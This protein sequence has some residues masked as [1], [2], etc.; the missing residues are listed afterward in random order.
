MR[1]PDKNEFLAPPEGQRIQEGDEDAASLID[2]VKNS[3]IGHAL[4]PGCT[5]N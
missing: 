5:H 4:A 3:P 2:T 1:S